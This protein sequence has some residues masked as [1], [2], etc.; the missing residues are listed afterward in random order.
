MVV[1]SDRSV[2][3]N[4]NINLKSSDGAEYL[5]NHWHFVFALIIFVVFLYYV[6]LI[7]L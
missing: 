5:Y 2:A 3:G 6:W 7:D 1:K 4:D